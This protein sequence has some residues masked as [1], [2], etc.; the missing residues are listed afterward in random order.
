MNKY[1]WDIWKESKYRVDFTFIKENK[2]VHTET[3]D[4]L[5]NFYEAKEYIKETYYNEAFPV[6]KKEREEAF[7]GC[8]AIKIVI[9]NMIGNA[10]MSIYY[11]H[12]KEGDAILE[13]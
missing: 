8:D 11:W 3:V 5:D 9:A 7:R 4:L 6:T 13:D 10:P 2:F 1:L 12:K